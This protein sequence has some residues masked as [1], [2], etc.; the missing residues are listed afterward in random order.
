MKKN[1]LG[2]CAVMISFVLISELT[3]ADGDGMVVEQEKVNGEDRVV[4]YPVGEGRTKWNRRVVRAEVLVNLAV[5]TDCTQLEDLAGVECQRCVVYAKDWR[6]ISY[7]TVELAMEGLEVLRKVEG[8]KSAE[9]VVE[10]LSE[11]KGAQ[12]DTYYQY[13]AAHAGY[14]WYL[15]NTGENGSQLGLDLNVQSVWDNYTGSGVKI[16]IVDDG[17]DISHPDLMV[18]IINDYD[19]NDETPNDPSPDS[20]QNHGTSSAGVAAAIGGNGLGVSG[21]APAAELVGLRL[22]GGAVSDVEEGEALQWRTNEIDIFSNSWGPSDATVV[23]EDSGPLVKAALA[24]AVSSG[25]SGKGCIFTWAG[26]NGKSVSVGGLNTADNSNYDGYANL[27]ETIA[28]GALNDRGERI[29]ERGVNIMVVGLSGGGSQGV[30]TTTSLA[31]GG[32]RYDFGG[33]SAVA[34]QVAGVSAL[35]LEVNPQ[36]GWRDVQEILLR[37]ARRVDQLDPEWQFNG[38]GFAFHPGYGAGL[39]DAAKAVEL[40]HGWTNLAVRNSQSLSFGGVPLSIPDNDSTGVVASFDFSTVTEMRVE[41][42]QVE[43]TL[44]HDAIGDLELTLISPSGKRSLLSEL[45]LDASQDL[46]W[47]FMSVHHWGETSDGL[48]QLEVRDLGSFDEG[49]LQSAKV[50]LHGVD[51]PHLAGKLVG[52]AN[53]EATVGKGLIHQLETYGPSES[54]RASGLPDGVYL[55]ASGELSGIPSVAGIYEVTLSTLLGEFAGELWIRVADESQAVELAQQLGWS[56]RRLVIAGTS[57]WKSG[58]DFEAPEV[59]VSVAGL[60]D[61]G[62]ASLLTEVNG[63]GEFRYQWKVSSEEG[64][65]YLELKL[66]GV[67]QQRISGELDWAEVVVDI[68]VG[69]HQIE[70]VYRHDASDDAG[71]DKAWI[72]SFSYTRQGSYTEWVEGYFSE[73]QKMDDKV[74][75]VDADP[76]K[77]GMSNLLEFY[78]GGDPLGQDIAKPL[79]MERTDDGWQLD[80]RADAAAKGVVHGV[81]YSQDLQTWTFIK[82]EKFLLDGGFYNQK[83]DVGSDGQQGFFRLKLLRE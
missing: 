25:R 24:S 27:P 33:T 5:G 66:D 8:V 55:S 73:A 74:S 2:V 56:S 23:Y 62:W 30:T 18:D 19:W 77:D 20:G 9:L 75:G 22:K 49:S 38:G 59:G 40:A 68:P 45:H 61:N 63:P 41:H 71:Q 47:T 35:I 52:K 12:N 81:E 72:D 67:I 13:D 6:V 48:W 64:F 32:Y 80:Y 82:G 50:I 29:S 17:L 53:L 51:K 42:A 39:V 44:D 78:R 37:S 11:L 4:L 60:D 43:V 70:W 3:G 28:V 58:A 65:D 15:Y 76:D 57:L 69:T 79:I 14:Q 83:V 21:V 54:Y 16:A 31:D 46:T 10:K 26:G 34:P 1:L 7:A 36:L